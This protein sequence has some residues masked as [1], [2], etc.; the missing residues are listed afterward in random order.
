[1]TGAEDRQL[2]RLRCLRPADPRRS[3]L[4]SQRKSAVNLPTN[5]RQALM[6]MMLRRDAV[7]VSWMRRPGTFFSWL[8]NRHLSAIPQDLF[9]DP[10]SHSSAPP[11]PALIAR[12]L[13]AAA[14]LVG[15]PSLC[16]LR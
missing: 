14:L 2:C 15:L 6:A 8:L 7:V 3:A 4:R 11:P 13:A 16:I 12:S 9:L 10:G 5:F 1:M